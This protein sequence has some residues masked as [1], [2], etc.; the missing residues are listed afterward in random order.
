LK[1]PA[2]SLRTMA[3]TAAAP[4]AQGTAF[5]AAS[6]LTAGSKTPQGAVELYDKWAE[7]YDKSVT[8]WGYEAPRVSAELVV[9]EAGA[10]ACVA[11][12]GCGT[13][14]S[15]YELRKA[16]ILGDLVGLDISQESLGLAN[17]RRHNDKEVYTRT[18]PTDLCQPLAD[19]QDGQ[20]D[21]VTC[22]GTLT[23]LQAAYDTVLS[24]W[25]RVLKPKG[26]CI[27]THKKEFQS[28][29]FRAVMEKYFEI[30]HISDLMPYLPKHPEFVGEAHMINYFVL[31][32]R[33]E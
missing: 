13:G 7:T 21:V 32:R 16:G 2:A 27:F 6:A 29:E 25:R 10:Q 26:L 19:L 18:H 17:Q 33:D 20:F 28:D 12:V 9:S 24:E 5:E 3:A 31:V 1:S 8:E 15:G 11:D 4:T 14:L 23:Y 30:K 22:V